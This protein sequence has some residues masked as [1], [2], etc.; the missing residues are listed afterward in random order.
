MAIGKTNAF[1]TVTAPKV[2]FGEVALNAQKFQQEADEKRLAKAAAKPKEKEVKPL[3]NW[4][5]L[6]RKFND[7]VPIDKEAEILTDHE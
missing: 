1:A 6:D 7:A 4:A 5:W 3:V 2:D